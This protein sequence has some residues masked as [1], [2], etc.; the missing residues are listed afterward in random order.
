VQVVAGRVIVAG[1]IAPVI[2]DFARQPGGGIIIA[3]D[4]LIAVNMRQIVALS[5]QHRLPGIYAF[6]D[7]PANGGLLSYGTAMAS[8]YG[9]AA[10]YTD[11]ILKGE[12]PAELPVQNPTRYQL[13]INLKAAKTLGIEPSAVMLGR[14]DEVIE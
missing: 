3:P 7:Y 10:T 14:A 12:K 5:D 8:I 13:V 6:R 11:R 1:E 2:A 4:S 9:G